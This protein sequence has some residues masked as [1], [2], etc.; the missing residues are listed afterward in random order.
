MR[1]IVLLFVAGGVG[2]FGCRTPSQPLVSVQASH[3]AQR[4]GSG[5]FASVEIL[6]TDSEGHAIP[7][8]E[9][10]LDVTVTVAGPDGHFND[11]APQTWRLTCDQGQTGDLAL[12][13]DNSGSENG[14]LQELQDAA[15]TM[16]DKVLDNDGRA[17]LV[18]VSTNSEVLVPLTSDRNAL[19]AGVSQMFIHKG[20]TALWDGVRMGNE[21]L[22]AAANADPVSGQTYT[23]LNSFCSVGRTFGV[24]AFTD[25]ADNNSSDEM[26]AQ[27]DTTRYPG[28]GIDTTYEDL[29]SLQVDGSQTPI[30][31]IG[32][33]HQVETQKLTDLAQS[34]GGRYLGIDATSQVGDVFSI[35]GNYFDA[36][37][38]V[39]VELPSLECGEFTLRVEY[40]W[41]YGQDHEHGVVD[42]PLSMPCQTPPEGRVATILLTTSDPGVPQ[43]AA[44]TLARQTVEWVSPKL[45]PQVLVVLDDNNHGEDQDDAMVV[46]SLLLDDDN[47]SITYAD[48]PADGLNA[49]DVA[50]YD[51]VWFSNPGYPMDDQRSFETLQAF[52]AG[53][54]GVVL[55]GDDMTW[56]W[57][58]GFSM[59]PVTHL[60]YVDNGTDACGTHI[61]N[62]QYGHYLVTISD[63]DH[64]IL[65]GLNGVSFPYGNDIDNSTPR[66]EGEQVLATATVQGDDTCPPRPVIVVHDPT[67]PAE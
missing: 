42:T 5:G 13:V 7:C 58:E 15:N 39:C 49:A 17:S 26:A 66:N 46:N 19:H 8:G 50:G 27:Y 61:D 35:I 30:Y 32:L 54:G 43:D 38:Q 22:G 48:E 10:T 31:A 40:D 55:Q 45:R 1:R 44:G 36:E 4:G 29:S 6:L 3:V 28:D 47:L 53:G 9:G 14:L 37:R 33:G 21:T 59:A 2:A 62:D 63:A 60:D 24:V 12:V 51:V 34:T 64:A 25:G 67:P 52:A 18:R 56:S 57:G 23:D 41:T 16:V 11:V 20:W 65:R